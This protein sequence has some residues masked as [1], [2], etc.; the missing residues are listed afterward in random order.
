LGKNNKYSDATSTRRDGK[1]VAKTYYLAVPSETYLPGFSG[2]GRFFSRGPS[3]FLAGEIRKDAR[4]LR[5]HLRRTPVLVYTDFKPDSLGH[6]YPGTDR[7]RPF[8]S[9][10]S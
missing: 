6:T 5:I 9:Q 4:F 8:Y 7:H 1:H 3:N 10:R 2:P